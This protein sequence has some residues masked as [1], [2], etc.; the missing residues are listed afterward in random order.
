MR[1]KIIVNVIISTGLR[2]TIIVNGSGGYFKWFEAKD[3]CECSYYVIFSI[4]FRL[5]IAV[6][7]TTNVIMWFNY[8]GLRLRIIISATSD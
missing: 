6:Y 2:L 7:A 4:D 1:L 5:N 3:S 8:T